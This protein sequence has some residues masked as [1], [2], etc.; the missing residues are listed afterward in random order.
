MSVITMDFSKKEFSNSVLDLILTLSTITNKQVELINIENP[1]KLTKENVKNISMLKLLTNSYVEGGVENSNKLHYSPSKLFCKKRFQLDLE[2]NYVFPIIN[3]LFLLSLFS[4]QKLNFK[5]KG[6]IDNMKY[7]SYDFIKETILKYVNSYYEINT[8]KLSSNKNLEQFNSEEKDFRKIKEVSLMIQ[9]KEKASQKSFTT[10]YNYPLSA[11]KLNVYLGKSCND[12]Y[13][14]EIVD[15]FK[16]YFSEKNIPLFSNIIYDEG[17]TDDILIN[18]F[19]IFGEEKDDETVFKY[20]KYV[21]AQFSGCYF[22]DASYFQTEIF[23]HMKILNQKILNK[24]ISYEESLFILPII[25]FFGGEVLVEEMTKEI[26]QMI[27]Y[28]ELFL[29]VKMDVKGN[30]VYCNNPYAKQK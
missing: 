25:A 30:F 16:L 10:N 14:K 29:E 3:S 2:N 20:T 4:E 22:S 28:L 27:K 19:L 8:V 17:Y 13:S 21:P 18:S 6:L 1:T 23:N 24:G 9:S 26:K 12:N 5:V 15:L 7:P 11:I